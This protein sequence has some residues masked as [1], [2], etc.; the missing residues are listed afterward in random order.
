[1]TL[2]YF[3]NSNLYNSLTRRLK[4]EILHYLAIERTYGRLR[5]KHFWGVGA[6]LY[7]SCCLK[8]CILHK[9]LR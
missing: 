1:M 7:D 6:L 5:E 4:Q 3:V 2:S 8:N 9:G